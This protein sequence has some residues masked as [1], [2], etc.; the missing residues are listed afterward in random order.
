MRLGPNVQWAAQPP[1]TRDASNTTQHPRRWHRLNQG[2]WVQPQILTE[3][4]QPVLVLDTKATHTWFLP[5]VRIYLKEWGRRLTGYW[6]GEP[7]GE[8]LGGALQSKGVMS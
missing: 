1:L 3:M 2:P 6:V 5:R 8:G 4:G 7:L